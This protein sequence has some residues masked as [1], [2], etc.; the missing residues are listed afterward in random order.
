MR[1]NL[2]HLPLGFSLVQMDETVMGRVYR[3]FFKTDASTGTRLILIVVLA[4]SVHLLVR[5][6]RRVG[7]WIIYRNQARKG[8]L[9]FM[10]QQPKFITVTPL[11]VSTITFA[12]YFFALGFFLQEFGVNLTAYLAS[13][14]VIGLAISF[15]LQGLVQDVISGL[16]MIFWDAMDVGDMVEIAGTVT[17]VGR[18]EEIGLRFTKLRNF[19]NQEIFIPNRTIANVSRF[20][21]GG[22]DAYADPQIPF[23]VD[24]EQAIALIRNCAHGMWVQ[25]GAIILSEPALG[26]V[27]TAEGGGWN[28]LRV[29]FKLWPGQGSLIETTFRQQLVRALKALDPGYAD[30]Q[31]PVT[32]RAM[33]G[34]KPAEPWRWKTPAAPTLGA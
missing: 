1:L 4:V 7:E 13:A 16:T 5:I 28:F 18:V 21:Q 31:V 24:Q 14:S 2:A 26:K 30:W 22:V 8:P 11:I 12:I 29:H 6:L 20:P 9:D 19:Y 15:G 32:Y 10:T 3:H 34:A 17:V 23:G 27:E 25:F 33:A